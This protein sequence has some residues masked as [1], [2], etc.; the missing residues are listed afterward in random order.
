M[1]RRISTAESGVAKLARPGKLEGA[2]AVERAKY[3]VSLRRRDPLMKYDDIIEDV[4][5]K[6]SCG[7]HVAIIAVSQARDR[8][9]RDFR[10]FS[11]DASRHIFEGLHEIHHEAMRR[12][13]L[14]VARKTLVDIANLFGLRTINV[15]ITHSIVPPSS[16]AALSM[17]QLDVLAQLDVPMLEGKII[18]AGEAAKEAIE[19]LDDD[20]DR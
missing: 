3:V 11:K 20:T 18:E 6:F 17:E 2:I 5:K 12:G 7:R 19:A 15:N 1:T 16:F 4:R 9:E 14:N 13:E 8:M 10:E